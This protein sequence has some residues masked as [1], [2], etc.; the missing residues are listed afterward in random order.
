ML[1]NQLFLGSILNSFKSFIQI[2][3]SRSTAKLKPLHGAIAEDLAQRLG[4]AY[5]IK[6]QGYG[7]D[8]EA[9]IRGR[10]INKKV[11]ITVVE[12]ESARPVA[13]VYKYAPKS[14][15]LSYVLIISIKTSFA[16]E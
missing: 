3:T 7:D 8:S 16:K 14:L 4:D 10:Y 12:K 5:I 2:G 13:G 15:S 9:V 1:T 11:D 6:S